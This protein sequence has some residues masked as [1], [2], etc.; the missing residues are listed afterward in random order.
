[1]LFFFLWENLRR[2]FWPRNL[3]TSDSPLPPSPLAQKTWKGES[4]KAI[5]SL[6]RRRRREGEG[7][8]PALGWGSLLPRVWDGG[9]FRRGEEEE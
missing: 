9:P 4:D 7:E 1:M 5:S 6:Q 3:S 2:V 8:I